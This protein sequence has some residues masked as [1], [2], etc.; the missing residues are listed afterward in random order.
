MQTR[1]EFDFS[2][3]IYTDT[4]SLYSREYI[5]NRRDAKI[6][7]LKHLSLSPEVPMTADNLI[8]TPDHAILT[9][10]LEEGQASRFSLK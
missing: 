7:F 3:A 10:P 5:A 8:L 4:G 6:D 1:V 2:H 9:L